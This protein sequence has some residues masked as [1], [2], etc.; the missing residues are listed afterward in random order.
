MIGIFVHS[1]LY[2]GVEIPENAPEKAT[3]GEQKN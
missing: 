1:G 2:P 3:A